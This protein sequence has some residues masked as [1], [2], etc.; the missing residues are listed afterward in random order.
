MESFTA[1]CNRS[2]LDGEAGP[3]GKHQNQ[4][5][6]SLFESH[7]VINQFI[8]HK[9]NALF[10][11]KVVFTVGFISCVTIIGKIKAI[12]YDKILSH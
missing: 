8:P 9:E 10:V 6:K 2:C 5:N 12:V 3:K 4:K 7:F 1:T 11:E